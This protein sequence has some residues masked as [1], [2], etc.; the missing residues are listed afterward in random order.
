MSRKAK[1]PALIFLVHGAVCYSQTASSLNVAWDA[2][3]SAVSGYFIY[4]V[5]AGT[6]ETVKTDV[7]NTTTA[8][9]NS[10]TPGHKYSIYVTAYDSS[11]ESMPSNVITLTAPS[12]AGSPTP[13]PSLSIDAGGQLWINGTAGIIYAIQ[14][15]SDLK[16]WIEI[17]QAKGALN[18][19]PFSDAPVAAAQT[20]FYRVAAQ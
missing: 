3:P 19:V 5:D 1:F 2:S 18:L 6:S 12:V 11:T 7:G 10:L 8:A 14:A 13:P 4:T 17:G 9:L 20:R 15:S 16:N